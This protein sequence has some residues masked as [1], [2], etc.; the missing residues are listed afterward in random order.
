MAGINLNEQKYDSSA[1]KIEPSEQPVET[2]Y[3]IFYQVRL[4]LY[5]SFFNSQGRSM[6]GL[7]TKLTW[8]K[9]QTGVD[10]LKHLVPSPRSAS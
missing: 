2:V 10:L 4:T 5:N 9:N 1:Y 6:Q 7:A 3:A 8:L